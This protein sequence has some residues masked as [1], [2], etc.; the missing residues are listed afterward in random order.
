MCTEYNS[1]VSIYL[2]RK[3]LGKSLKFHIIF[4]YIFLDDRIRDI[5]CNVEFLYIE[6]EI[7]GN[8]HNNRHNQI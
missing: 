2:N 3:M 1:V 4:I 5:F 7:Y 8:V 6:N